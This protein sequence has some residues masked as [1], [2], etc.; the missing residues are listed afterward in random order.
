MLVM[1]FLLKNFAARTHFML[2][3]VSSE[4]ICHVSFIMSQYFYVY[5]VLLFVIPSVT[6]A[7]M[8]LAYHVCHEY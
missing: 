3:L 8:V 2:I 6:H 1:M 4:N 5:P 7:S